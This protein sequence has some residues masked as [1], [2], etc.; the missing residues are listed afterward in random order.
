MPT[1]DLDNLHGNQEFAFPSNLGKIGLPNESSPLIKLQVTLK[2][3]HV[4][5]L[6]DSGATHD[7]VSQGVLE[8]HGWKS[9][10]CKNEDKILKIE[11]GDHSIVEWPN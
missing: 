8:L 7:F 3:Q 6:V 2:G 1:A 5:I 4:C 9:T 10:Q 11:L